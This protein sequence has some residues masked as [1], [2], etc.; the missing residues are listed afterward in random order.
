MWN[1][2]LR[3]NKSDGLTR[4]ERTRDLF[5]PVKIIFFGVALSGCGPQ[6]APLQ[7]LDPSP[8]AAPMEEVDSPQEQQERFNV[9]LDR[10]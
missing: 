10:A 2:A 4:R 6:G 7:P 5:M 3:R 8:E 1:L 9:F